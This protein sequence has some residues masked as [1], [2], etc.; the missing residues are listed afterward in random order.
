MSTTLTATVEQRPE[1][2]RCGRR[3]YYLVYRGPVGEAVPQ[4]VKA[5]C[6]GCEFMPCETCD[7]VQLAAPKTSPTP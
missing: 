1:L 2:C 5:Y 4:T 3:A 6:P 7:C